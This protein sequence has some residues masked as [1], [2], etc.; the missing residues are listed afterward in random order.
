MPESVEDGG[1]FKP[2]W[3][4]VDGT[5]TVIIVGDGPAG[6][7]AALKL[8]EYGIKP[9]IIE[10]GPDASTRKRD[11][12]DISSKGFVNENSNYCFGEGGAGTFSNGQLFTRSN[13]R[14]NIS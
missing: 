7:F 9:I 8:I 1:T 3:Q 12:A 11:I 13:K 2:K 5:K 4:K 14:C 6:I 10:R